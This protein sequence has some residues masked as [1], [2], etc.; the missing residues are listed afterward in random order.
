MHSEAMPD[1]FCV[2]YHWEEGSVPPPYHYEY[3]LRLGPGPEGKVTF[4]PDYPQHNP[5]VWHATFPL[6]PDALPGLYSLLVMHGLLQARWRRPER[7]PVGGSLEWAEVTAG[8]RRLQFPAVLA[9]R[10]AA[11]L[12]PFY[13]A[14]RAAAPES[15]WREMDE[16]RKA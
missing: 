7:A 9:P 10:D 5:E 15:V 11:R 12:R 1:D 16:R 14:V 2:V 13:D 8:G 6:A 3:T 4:W